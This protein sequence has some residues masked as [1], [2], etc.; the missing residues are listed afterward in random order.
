MLYHK[1][2]LSVIF[3]EK[4]LISAMR[5]ENITYHL[6]TEGAVVDGLILNVDVH[7]RTGSPT[8]VTWAKSGRHECL[9]THGCR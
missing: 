7:K 9:V 1:V 6:Y 2:L 3:S 5:E 4:C 8:V